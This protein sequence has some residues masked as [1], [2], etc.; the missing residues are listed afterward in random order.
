MIRQNVSLQRVKIIYYIR[1]WLI[2]NID[3]GQYRCSD[4]SPSLCL[5]IK[6]KIKSLYKLYNLVETLNTNNE[7]LDKCCGVSTDFI[8]KLTVFFIIIGE[9]ASTNIPWSKMNRLKKCNADM[10]IWTHVLTVGWLSSVFW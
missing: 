2:V 3:Y 10:S 5:E 8:S 9:K 4:C 1:N 6:N 7:D